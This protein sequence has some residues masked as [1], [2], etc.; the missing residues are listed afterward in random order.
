[1][2]L[3]KKHVPLGTVVVWTKFHRKIHSGYFIWKLFPSSVKF[4]LKFSGSRLNAYVGDDFFH[5][6]FEFPTWASAM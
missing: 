4:M 3:K 2:D 6:F 1:M 5:D